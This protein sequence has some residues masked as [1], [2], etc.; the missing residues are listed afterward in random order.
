MP[1]A[2]K[3]VAAAQQQQQ[4]QQQQHGAST[5]APPPPPTAEEVKK[6]RVASIKPATASQLMDIKYAPPLWKVSA[7]NIVAAMNCNTAIN[8]QTKNLEELMDAHGY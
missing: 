8:A 5:L 3:K 7:R 4:Q 2:S 6:K 1:R